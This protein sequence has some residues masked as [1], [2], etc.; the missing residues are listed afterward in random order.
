M[1]VDEAVLSEVYEAARVAF[2]RLGKGA[3]CAFAI[4][5]AL[6]VHLED[7]NAGTEEFL[8]QHFLA[9]FCGAAIKN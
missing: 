5:L 3:A 9:V 7:P 6:T 8:L 1:A 4:T 2:Y